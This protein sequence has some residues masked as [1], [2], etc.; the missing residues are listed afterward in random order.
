MGKSRLLQPVGL[1]CEAFD[2]VSQNGLFKASFGHGDQ[3]FGESR[4]GIRFPEDHCTIRVYRNGEA[5]FGVPVKQP[6]DHLMT[7]QALGPGKFLIFLIHA[8]ETKKATNVANIF[9]G[10]PDKLLVSL[11]IGNC[12]LPSSSGTTSP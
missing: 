3:Y 9:T 4:R 5:V 8:K 11:L 10:K 6:A 12:Q 7:F 1:P 2:A